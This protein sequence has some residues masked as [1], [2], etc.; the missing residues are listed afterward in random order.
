MLA[1]DTEEKARICG[2]AKAAIRLQLCDYEAGPRDAENQDSCE[3]E[4]GSDK[5]FYFHENTC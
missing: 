4:Y 3:L 5:E 2:G 1:W